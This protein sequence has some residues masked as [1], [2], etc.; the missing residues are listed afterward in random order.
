M[1][2]RLYG[3]LGQCAPAIF[4]PGCMPAASAR[5]RQSGRCAQNVPELAAPRSRERARRAQ[6]RTADPGPPVRR[7]SANDA[8]AAP[9]G[10]TMPRPASTTPRRTASMLYSR[11]VSVLHSP[12]RSWTTRAACIR[13]SGGP[14]RQ[15]LPRHVERAPPRHARDGEAPGAPAERVQRVV[16]ERPHRVAELGKVVAVPQ[17]VRVLVPGAG[18]DGGRHARQPGAEHGLGLEP[19]HFGVPLVLGKEP[20]LPHEPAEPPRVAGRPVHVVAGRDGDGR[21]GLHFRQHDLGVVAG[22]V[23]VA[24]AEHVVVVFRVQAHVEQPRYARK[25]R[26][27]AACAGHADRAGARRLVSCEDRRRFVRRAVVYGEDRRGGEGLAEE[28]VYRAGQRRPR[29]AHGG[30]DVVRGAAAAA[31]RRGG[32]VGGGHAPCAGCRAIRAF[33]AG[34]VVGWPRSG[35]PRGAARPHGPRMPGGPLPPPGEIV[36]GC[37]VQTRSRRVAGRA[38]RGVSGRGGGGPVAGGPRSGPALPQRGRGDFFIV[39]DVGSA[40]TTHNGGPIEPM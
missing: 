23:A 9:P 10:P 5:P 18:V 13:R 19:D 3:P 40:S 8:S 15:A 11:A 16:P 2:V 6:Y 33:R 32:R 12:R 34:L 27:G 24:G 1:F 38:G 28:A 37:F 26:R 29:V 30:D 4:F 35:L 7:R 25:V 14:V 22:K 39:H 21:V 17:P 31:G 20:R 36:A